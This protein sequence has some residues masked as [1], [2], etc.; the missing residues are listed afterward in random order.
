LIRAFLGRWR[1]GADVRHTDGVVGSNGVTAPCSV[2]E[3]PAV[4]H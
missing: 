4:S 2:S 1:D 3:T